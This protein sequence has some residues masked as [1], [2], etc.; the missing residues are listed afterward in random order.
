VTAWVRKACD[1]A[2]S[3]RIGLDYEDYGYGARNLFECPCAGRGYRNDDIWFGLNELPGKAAKAD[4]LFCRKLVQEGDIPA[5][6]VTELGER[7]DQDI[8]IFP[9]LLSIRRVPK[10]ANDRNMPGLLPARF[11]QVERESSPAR[12]QIP[13]ASCCSAPLRS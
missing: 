4:G 6:G 8:E 5:I 12:R 2:I 3:D 7:V 1:Q 13:A 10:D 11:Q 9:L